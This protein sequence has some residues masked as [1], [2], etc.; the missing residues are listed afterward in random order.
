L[1][2]LR[3]YFGG[4]FDMLTTQFFDYHLIIKQ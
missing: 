3:D 2:I 1:I 4:V